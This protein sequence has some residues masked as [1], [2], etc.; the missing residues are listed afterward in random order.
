MSLSSQE[1]KLT[2]LTLVVARAVWNGLALLAIAF[3]FGT[4]LAGVP[5]F[6]RGILLDL[7]SVLNLFTSEAWTPEIVRAEAEGLGVPAS[8]PAWSWL[9]IEFVLLTSFGA[10]G[11]VL[12]SQ[13]K[14]P[15][16][17][18]PTTERYR[19]SES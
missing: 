11:L 14:Q 15:C 18:R 4:W 13:N 12:Y 16:G 9:W 6:V 1:G 17:I 7:D 2:G 5:I 19:G 3:L 10:A 8:L